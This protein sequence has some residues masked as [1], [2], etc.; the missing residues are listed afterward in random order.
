M[1]NTEQTITDFSSTKRALLE[2]RL[3]EDVAPVQLQI[4]TIDRSAP[5][6][7]SFAQ[8][9][10]W[11]THQLAPENPTHN[12]PTYFRLTG[13]LNVEVLAQSLNEIVC[14]HEVLRSYFPIVNGQPSLKIIPELLL[15]LSINDISDLSKQTEQ[16]QTLL[17]QEIQK[18]FD[19]ANGPLI[20]TQ[21]LK[22]GETEHL[23]L[24]T[25]HHSVFDD[26]SEDILK[27]EIATLYQAFSKGQPN[28][29]ID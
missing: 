13:T 18:P 7:L 10:M 24:I 27:Q 14:R 6:A 16:L 15:P 29:L 11:F 4:E 12:R 8:Q 23:L 22:L 1:N 19:L 26:W 25:L 28:P 21:L 20:R 3:K 9:R 5:L 2:Q 17:R